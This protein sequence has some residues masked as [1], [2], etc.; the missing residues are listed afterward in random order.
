M[1]MIV[2]GVTNRRPNNNLIKAWNRRKRSPSGE[3]ERMKLARITI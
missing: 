3:G 1:A 2:I